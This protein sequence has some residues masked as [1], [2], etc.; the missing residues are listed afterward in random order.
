VISTQYQ[1]R[2]PPK[3]KHPD[4][5]HRDPELLVPEAL[6]R[7][8]TVLGMP[9]VGLH[10]GFEMRIVQTAHDAPSLLPNNASTV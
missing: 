2:D 7:L 3:N 5:G 6:R 1:V 9:R 10:H 8:L 4:D